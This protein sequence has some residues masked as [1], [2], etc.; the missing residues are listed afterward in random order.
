M[1]SY[2]VQNFSYI[3]DY[4]IGLPVAQEYKRIHALFLFQG[5]MTKK[6]NI[7]GRLNFFGS[8]SKKIGL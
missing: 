2:N 8:K 5:F 4:I 3:W 1:T 6:F 7:P